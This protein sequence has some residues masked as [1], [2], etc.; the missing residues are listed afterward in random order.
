MR[1]PHVEQGPGP[2]PPPDR[3][4]RRPP[5]PPLPRLPALRRE[6]PP[7]PPPLDQRLGVQGHVTP[8]ARKL[9]SLAGAS[10]SFQGAAGHLLEFCGLRV[11]GQTV[12]AVC[13]EEAGPL[14]DRL[15]SAPEAGEGFCQAKG[16]AEFYTDGTMVNTWEGWREMRLGAFAKRE[17]GNPGRFANWDGRYLPKTHARD[18]FGSFETAE[19]FGPRWRAWAGRQ[20][21]CGPT[22]LTVLADGA[23]WIWRRVEVFLAGTSGVLD[24]YHAL[25]HTGACANAVFGEGDEEG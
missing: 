8:H 3:R 21:I 10:W 6:P 7:Q 2:A 1:T 18:L 11:C 12:R 14:A 15:Q 24:V 17:R 22:D 16:D 19:K 25:E 9:L 5:G 13:F 23:E 20:G 4:R